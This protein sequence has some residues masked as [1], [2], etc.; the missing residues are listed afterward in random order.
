MH[1]ID[2]K[3]ESNLYLATLPII[4]YSISISMIFRHRDR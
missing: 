4:I 2:N 1:C 3:R